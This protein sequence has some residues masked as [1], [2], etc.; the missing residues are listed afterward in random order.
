MTVTE[1][2]QPLS[3]QD[4]IRQWMERYGID[5]T[6]GLRFKVLD[7]TGNR[8]AP[9][10]YSYYVSFVSIWGARERYGYWPNTV[11]FQGI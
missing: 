2:A 7:H 4:I 5:I 1:E 3:K 6:K 11:G 10:R 8:L 9:E